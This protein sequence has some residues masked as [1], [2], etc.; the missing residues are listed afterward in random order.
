MLRMGVDRHPRAVPRY[1]RASCGLCTHLAPGIVMGSEAVNRPG[2]ADR[3]GRVGMARGPLRPQVVIA[4]AAAV[5]SLSACAGGGPAGSDMTGPPVTADW[6]ADHPVVLAAN[7]SNILGAV[8]AAAAA[9]PRGGGGTQ[10][11]NHD[12]DGATTDHARI[13]FDGGR[14]TL[15]VTR[16]DGSRVT[17]A[18]A[19]HAASV[20]EFRR[21]RLQDHSS[22]GWTALRV[23]NDSISVSRLV[24]SW[25]AYDATDYLAG[26]YW[27]HFSDLADP[28]RFHFDHVEVGAVVDGPGLATAFHM[29]AAGLASYSGPVHGYFAIADGAAAG[30]RP[31]SAQGSLEV[32]SFSATIDLYASFFG[33]APL[34]HGCIGC[35]APMRFHALAVDEAS[36]LAGP[37]ADSYGDYEVAF[38]LTRIAPDGTFGGSDVRVHVSGFPAAESAGSWGGRLS[39]VQDSEGEPRSAAG[40]FGATFS[41]DDQRRGA[42]AGMFVGWEP[43][44]LVIE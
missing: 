28:E 39:G 10:S 3:H 42:F 2:P 12:V 29:P 18:T 43:S 30:E 11:S 34:I 33:E 17:L 40:T 6:Q 37:L 27:L 19:D 7:R 14:P 41:T 13:T 23:T 36:G 1:D 31:R 9:Q 8:A 21:S 22:G 32:G 20:P 44:S 4:L 15:A 25:N 24:V 38:D 5:W 26:A 35:G 16:A